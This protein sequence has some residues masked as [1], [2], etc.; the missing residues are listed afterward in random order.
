MEGERRKEKGGG[1]DSTAGV[2]VLEDRE[3]HQ[4]S[5]EERERGG[6][7]KKG[8]AEIITFR[9][10]REQRSWD[11]QASVTA[12]GESAGEQRQR[13]GNLGVN[14]EA[15]LEMSRRGFLPAVSRRRVFPSSPWPLGGCCR[16]RVKA[17]GNVPTV[18]CEP[19]RAG[20]S[21]LRS[22]DGKQDRVKVTSRV[23]AR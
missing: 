8:P 20:P 2:P 16:R 14:L 15:G 3:F 7:W 12:L 6:G 9:T 11:P 1:G 22:V 18:S 13:A 5:N 4:N 21:A 23:P 17:G 19:H 10:K